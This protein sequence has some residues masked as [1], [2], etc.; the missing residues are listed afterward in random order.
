MMLQVDVQCV[1]KILPIH[2]NTLLA[3]IKKI[4]IQNFEFF[5]LQVHAIVLTSK[6]EKYNKI[7]IFWTASKCRCTDE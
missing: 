4:K 5:G 6:L 7:L 1:H 2:Q 3:C